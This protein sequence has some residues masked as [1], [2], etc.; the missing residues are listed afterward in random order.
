MI[1]VTVDAA[2]AIRLLDRIA[3]LG[4]QL[5]RIMATTSRVMEQQVRQSFRDERAPWGAP[6]PP[7]APS[8][9]KARARKSASVQRLVDTGAMFGSIA[10]SSTNTQ[11]SV[12][13]GEGLPDVRTS[14]HQSGSARVPARP[15]F[16]IHAD[17]RIDETPRWWDPVLRPLRD[18]L[19]EAVA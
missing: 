3:G 17:G 8:T 18:A 16:P 10:P 4:Q 13:M 12:S 9:R 1:K 5:P 2:S 14:V 6:W 11:A 15:T 19:A 7:H